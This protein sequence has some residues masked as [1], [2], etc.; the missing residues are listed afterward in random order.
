MSFYF[1]E[2]T[3]VELQEY[4]EKN[5]VVIIPV[6]TTE[7]HGRHLPVETD[8]M[9]AKYYGDCLGKACEDEEIPVLVTQPIYFGFSMAIV[10]KWPGCINIDTRT[11][12]NYI[13]N[14]VNSLIEM[15]FKKIVLL[16]C[17]GNHDSLL[18]TVMREIA[19]KHN[20]YIMTL[21]PFSLSAKRYNEIKKDPQGDIHG[22]EWETSAIMHIRPDLVHHDEFTNVDAIR[23]NTPLR[24]PVST[25]GLQETKT[26]LFG[27]PTY[28]TPELGAEVFK[29]ATEEGLKLIKEYYK[30]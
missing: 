16:D 25:W 17:H 5:A 20:I 23:C 18:R 29:A 19:D 1:G 8:A 11:F 6:G 14:M 9:I 2:K 22:G 30:L 7:E 12:M 13:F 15:G 10:R 24:G 27:D 4:I 3:W 26:G 28:A 21:R